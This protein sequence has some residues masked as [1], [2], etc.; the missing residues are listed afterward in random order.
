M[1]SYHSSHE[2]LKAVRLAQE[3][4]NRFLVLRLHALFD[5]KGGAVAGCRVKQNWLSW[6]RLPLEYAKKA[7][8]GWQLRQRQNQYARPT[9]IL[10][11]HCANPVRGGF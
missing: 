2:S 3:P 5:L 4:N 11:L 7:N 9:R 10:L 1:Q 6:G 8:Q